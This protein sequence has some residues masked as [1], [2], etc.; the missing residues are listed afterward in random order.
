MIPIPTIVL[1]KTVLALQHGSAAVANVLYK[2]LG[3][4]VFWQG[5][6]FSLPGVNI[7]IAQE[8]SGIR[9]S[10][11]LF[12]AGTVAAHV[13]LRSGSSKVILILSTIPIAIFKNAV[14]IVTISSLAVYV[15][16]GFLYGRLHKY[17]GLPFS[18]LALAILVPLLFCLQKSEAFLKTKGAQL[19]SHR[20]LQE[21]TVRGEAGAK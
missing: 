15:D 9:S 19:E 12:I 5:V 7:E 6:T 21:L 1:E 11:A 10:V 18:I 2:L 14:R 17:G 3:V 8:C 13:F 4:P 16:R 20:P